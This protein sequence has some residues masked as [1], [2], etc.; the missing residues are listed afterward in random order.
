MVSIKGLVTVGGKRS[1]AQRSGIIDLRE[2]GKVKM[3][4]N[5]S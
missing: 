4:K 5:Y 1:Q 3:P 2:G